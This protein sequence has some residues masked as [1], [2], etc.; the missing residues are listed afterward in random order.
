[1]SCLSLNKDFAS[2]IQ[3]K[4]SKINKWKIFHGKK[5]YARNTH[6]HRNFALVYADELYTQPNPVQVAAE[7][8][9]VE[10]RK[11]QVKRSELEEGIMGKIERSDNSVLVGIS[12]DQSN[13]DIKEADDVDLRAEIFI[14]KF[15]EEMRKQSDESRG[16]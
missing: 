4:I 1:M 10:M 9:Q 14:R 3:Y 15:K 11:D 16:F 8:K 13:T 2:I 12:S 5:R 6:R 7:F